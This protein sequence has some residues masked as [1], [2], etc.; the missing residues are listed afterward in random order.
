LNRTGDTVA[1][2]LQEPDYLRFLENEAG[3]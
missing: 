1:A 3:G 2:L